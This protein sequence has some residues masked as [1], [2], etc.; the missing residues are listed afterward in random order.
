MSVP[1][2]VGSQSVTRVTHWEPWPTRELEECRLE[3]RREP[4][5]KHR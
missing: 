1:V 4:Q 2:K 5:G 3:H